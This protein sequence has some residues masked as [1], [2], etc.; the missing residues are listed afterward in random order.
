[1][2]LT[3]YVSRKERRRGLASIHDS[4][5]YMKKRRGRLITATRNKIDK[6]QQNSK[7]RLC[8]DREECTKLAQKEFKIRH[9]SV[10]KVINWELC[11]NLKFDDANK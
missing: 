1:M 9:E 11:K 3:D 6:M 4:V 2:P 5:D 8:G 7:C 10:G